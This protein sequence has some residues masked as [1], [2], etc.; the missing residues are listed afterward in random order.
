MTTADVLM[1]CLL[2]LM[3]SGLYAVNA[4]VKA[5]KP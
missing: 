4:V 3:A 2:L 1:T 5:G